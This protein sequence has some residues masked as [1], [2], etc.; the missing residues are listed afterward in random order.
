MILVR[1]LFIVT[2]LLG[3]C[4]LAVSTSH[5][6]SPGDLYKKCDSWTETMSTC[7]GRYL[8]QFSFSTSDKTGGSGPL[9]GL[10]AQIAKDF[11]RQARWVKRDAAGGVLRWFQQAS[12]PTL[13]QAMI[14]NLL[15]QLKVN[16]DITDKVGKVDALVKA[17]APAGDKRWLDLYASIAEEVYGDR[18]DRPLIRPYTP[19]PYVEPVTPE[20]RTLTAD[21]AQAAL[22]ADWMH[23][24]G[25][26]PGVQHATR[27]IAWARELAA[28]LAAGKSAPNLQKELA[29]L[30]VL[31]K[32]LTAPKPDAR[33]L[34]LAVRA[35]KRRITFKNPL[36]D[37]SSVLLVDNPYPQG[38]TGHHESGHRNGIRS[39]PGGRLLPWPIRLQ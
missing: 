19:G 20:T 3:V 18:L 38:A 7:R 5:A 29:E 31:E 16:Y 9:A 4:G 28:R 34:Y 32:K 15:R 6:A 10:W 17:K 36:V 13:E 24:V 27:E 39:R 23:Q 12:E 1:K 21:E 8:K 11:P 26:R 35:V 14:G 2:V 33:G 22:E 25:N 37:F 30:A